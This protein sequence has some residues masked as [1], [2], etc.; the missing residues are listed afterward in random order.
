M[1]AVSSLGVASGY[2]FWRSYAQVAVPVVNVPSPSQWRCRHAVESHQCPAPARSVAGPYAAFC[3][4][5][6]R[7]AALNSPCGSLLDIPRSG[8]VP[9]EAS[10]DA[11]REAIRHKHGGGSSMV[12]R[13]GYDHALKS[14]DVGRPYGVLPWY[15]RISCNA[16]RN[17]ED[18]SNIS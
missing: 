5:A 13:V 11:P 15:Y 14:C 16:N 2:A 17:C 4:A 10:R 9:F 7:W 12:E 6:R 1:S 3:L 8:K 18:I